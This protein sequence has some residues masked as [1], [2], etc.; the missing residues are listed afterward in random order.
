[1]STP[2]AIHHL[3]IKINGSTIEAYTPPVP[4]EIR[5][6]VKCLLPK[7][8]KGIGTKIKNQIVFK[9]CQGR[10]VHYPGVFHYLDKEFDINPQTKEK[11]AEI[12]Q[13]ICTFH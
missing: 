9:V 5:S 2:N 8:S 1:M 3:S 10:P 6:F 7:E 12:V 4:S 11:F 13:R